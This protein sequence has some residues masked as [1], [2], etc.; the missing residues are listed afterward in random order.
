MKTLQ[1]F[2]VGLAVATMIVSGAIASETS[3]EFYIGR[4]ATRKEYSEDNF[5]RHKTLECY[6]EGSISAAVIT[7]LDEDGKIILGRSFHASKLLRKTGMELPLLDFVELKSDDERFKLFDDEPFA[8]L[9]Y[10]ERELHRLTKF[11]G[12]YSKRT[13]IFETF[14]D[15]EYSEYACNILSSLLNKSGIF[16]REKKQTA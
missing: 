2:A 4:P 6:N 11:G 15:Q 13:I 10:P 5:F 7:R 1:R 3:G 12:E 9:K 8:F 16:P 14:S